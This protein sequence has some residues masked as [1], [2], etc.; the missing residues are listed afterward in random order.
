MKGF[1]FKEYLLNIFLLL[2]VL[3]GIT[4]ALLPFGEKDESKK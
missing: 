2:L 3:S 1:Y 4:N